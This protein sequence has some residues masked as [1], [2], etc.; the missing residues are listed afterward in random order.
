LITLTDWRVG[1]G[2]HARH[3]SFEHSRD[4]GPPRAPRHAT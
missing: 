2:P 3:D 1:G 4:K